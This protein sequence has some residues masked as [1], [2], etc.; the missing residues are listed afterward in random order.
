VLRKPLF[1]LVANPSQVG[2]GRIVSFSPLLNSQPAAATRWRWIPSPAAWDSVAGCPANATK[3]HRVMWVSGTMRAYRNVTST[4]EDSADAIVT[5]SL[6]CEPSRRAPRAPTRDVARA[7]R[8]SMSMTLGCDAGGGLGSEEV[9]GLPM[10]ELSVTEEAHVTGGPATTTYPLGVVVPYSY[11]GSGVFP[12]A[13][14]FLG[15]SVAASTG[16]VV[17][18]S[19]ASIHAIAEVPDSWVDNVIYLDSVPALPRPPQCPRDSVLVRSSMVLGRLGVLIDST[20]ADSV[21]H[22]SF[23]LATT[24]GP[25]VLGPVIHGEPTRVVMAPP[26]DSAC[27]ALHAHPAGPQWLEGPNGGD[28][29]FGSLYKIVQMLV[30]NDYI[31]FINT[32]RTARVIGRRKKP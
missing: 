4:I 29:F 13:V 5:V 20:L 16:A 10:V 2:P 31:Y 22:G 7:A 25:I 26:P 11:G 15:D 27:M 28:Y 23:V 6:D 19:G 32:D 17:A 12:S 1:E 24:P 30:T 3:C 14:V 18:D 9:G 8:A 21:E